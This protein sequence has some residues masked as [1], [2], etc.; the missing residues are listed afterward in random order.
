MTVTT[1]DILQ[2]YGVK[3]MKWGVRKNKA[4]KKGMAVTLNAG[5]KRKHTAMNKAQGIPVPAPIA[6]GIVL[7]DSLANRKVSK[8]IAG[9]FDSN[10]KD[11]D[12]QHLKIATASVRQFSDVTLSVDG[13]TV[14]F[15]DYGA[16]VKERKSIK[17]SV[18]LNAILQHHGVKGMKW[19]VHRSASA[20]RK[21]AAG[22]RKKITGKIREHV[23]SSKRERSW[24]SM[25]VKGMPANDIQKLAQRVQLENDLKKYSKSKSQK[26]QYRNRASMA[27][28][29][30][31]E[32]VNQHR[33]EA[34]FE[35]TALQAN[36]S[37]RDMAANAVKTAAPIAMKY[38]LTQNVT[39]ADLIMS[40]GPV[41]ASGMGKYM[42][43]KMTSKTPRTIKDTVKSEAQNA[44]VGNQEGIGKMTDAVRK[45]VMKE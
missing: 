23:E 20:L 8:K 2:H 17:Q 7:T 9:A 19:G 39:K 6:L 31:R 37:Q 13:K 33:A 28:S 21:A 42:E 40:L 34:F 4:P 14:D 22:R 1:E 24:A 30:I 36:K 29:D 32:V 45:K 16:K 27:D 12:K 43:K 3:G 25:D 10:S 38:A 15:K 41:A 18:E 11:F 5:A 44:I 35:R 26:A